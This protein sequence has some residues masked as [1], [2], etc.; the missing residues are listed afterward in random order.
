MSGK[1]SV[2]IVDFRPLRRN[3][4]VGFASVRIN[5]LRLVIHDVAIHS[6]GEGGR[7]VQ[8][9][10]KPQLD[11]NGVQL[12]DARTGKPLFSPVLEF[13]DWKVRVAFS[14]AV[15]AALLD[16]FPRAFVEEGAA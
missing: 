6:K 10:A 9:P 4:L 11:K 15:C 13:P 16:R 2:A 14:H 12:R 1:F 5:E 3:T 7:W 8:L